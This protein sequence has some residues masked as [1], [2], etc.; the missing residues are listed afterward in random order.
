[1][2]RGALRERLKLWELDPARLPGPLRRIGE[3]EL[4][5]WV[6]RGDRKMDAWHAFH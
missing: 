6:C 5:L 2:T 4:H 1:M 3:K